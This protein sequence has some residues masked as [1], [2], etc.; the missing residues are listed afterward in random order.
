MPDEEELS[1]KAYGYILAH[2]RANPLR[3]GATI[4]AVAVAV[5]FLIVVGSLS[6]GLEGATQ[7]EILDYTN[8]TPNLPIG[9][10]I[11]TE[12]GDYVGLFATRLFDTEEVSAIEF[13]AQ[14]FVGSAAGTN[15]YPYSERVLAQEHFTGFTYLVDRLIA[16][17]PARGLTTPYTT[18][19]DYMVLSSGEH[20]D[21]PGARDV[22]LGNRIWKERF[23]GAR[24]G[25]MIDLAPEDVTWFET[26]VDDLRARG[27]L[28]LTRLPALSGLRLRGVL[29]MD[30]STD[31]NAY[32]PLGMFANV[33]GAGYDTD[34]PRSE[35]ISV[36][37]REE[38]VD[39]E[40]LTDKLMERSDRV[41]SFYLTSTRSAAG[42]QLAEDLSSAIYG[43]LVLAVAVILVGM[44]LGVA[45]TSFLSV[46]QRVR[47]IGT[48]RA[49]GLS[50]D[51]IRK[52]VQWE[53]L[54]IG[55]MG[56]V[57]G[58]FAGT[59]LSSNV[60]NVLYEIED[61]G[62]WLAPGRTVPFLVVGSAI[63]VIIAALVGAE[64]PAR[65][66]SDMSPMEA[67]SAPL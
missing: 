33:T 10:F 40:A 5:A 2:A 42:S 51:Q 48:L 11:Q 1:L 16:V 26:E 18:Y 59:I 39:M 3:T 50:R 28:T 37:V 19:H 62:L 36:E 47:E 66:A 12:E 17:D 13:A 15:T 23:T 21:D 8:S 4:T 45:N 7:R 52:L 46:S 63:A 34:G 27:P 20:L 60:L 57:I 41:T 53:S 38:D 49:I 9:D 29:D 14:Q 22:V 6:V 43:W 54:F 61:L 44:V 65:K 56:W 24:P 55:M 67:L 30:L 25:D 64:I 32:V 31:G 58:F 35:A